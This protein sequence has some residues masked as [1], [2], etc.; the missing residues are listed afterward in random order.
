MDTKLSNL[1][2][3]E[4]Q[5]G[6]IKGR[7]RAGHLLQKKVKMLRPKGDGCFVLDENCILQKMVR[8]RYAIEPTIVVPRKIT[9]LI[10]VEFHNGKGYQGISCTVNMIRH[11]FWWVSMCR[12]VHQH[13]S[14]CQLC[15]QFLPNWLYTQAMH[16]EIPKVPFTGFAMD[17][18]S[19]LPDTSKGNRHA[20]T[21]ICFV[22]FISNHGTV[23]M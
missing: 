14:S 11:Y 19:P 4:A 13:I 5:P 3:G 7:A 8:L 18:I 21:F 10:I 17:C 12:D 2:N 9:C 15:I 20:L 16:L 6:C 1:P 23:K 22:N